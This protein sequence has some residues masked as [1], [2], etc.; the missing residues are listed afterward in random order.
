MKKEKTISFDPPATF[1]DGLT[2]D[3]AV[4]AAGK[5]AVSVE[6]WLLQH[7]LILLGSPAV[8]VKL[9]NG[10]KI[11][12]C[13]KEPTITALIRNRNALYKL[14]A[15]PNLYFGDLYSAG[16]IEV[17]GDLLQFLEI[18]YTAMLRTEHNAG[19]IKKRITEFLTRAP[20]ANTLAGS[21]T[22]IDHHYD[23][24]NE[25][26][27][28][29][30]DR[31]HMQYTCAYYPDEAMTLQQAQTAKLEHICRKLELKPG[32]TVVEAGCGWG[33]LA[34]YM[35]KHYDVKVKSYNI[36]HEQ[37][38]FA[39]QRAKDQGLDGKVEYI[40]D[41]YRNI[42]GEFDAFVS[43]GM[44]EHVGHNNYSKLGEVIH[45]CLKPEG[46]GFIHSIGRNEP[47]LMN[48]WIEKRIFPGAYPPAL[49]EMMDIFEPSN[50][51]VQDVENL[52]RHYARTL[53]HWLQRYDENIEQVEAMFDKAF[54]RAWRLYLVGSIAAFNTGELQ[55]FQI[56]FTRPQNNP[57][58]YSRA[59]LYQ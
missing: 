48:A 13:D 55:L 28:L 27:T 35:A 57:L 12:V 39:R 45:R 38:I 31:D 51:S 58:S 19:P 41:D 50:F 52:G 2:Y 15:N 32:E 16:Q 17:E 25:F 53:E 9:W 7:M 22:H 3:D 29:W 14:L 10:D 54:V 56:L 30:L 5:N 34:R 59:H 36:S 43:I 46:R 33:G 26:Y 6:I 49:R 18:S 37:V 23:I 21:R 1:L 40:E 42:T 24:G 8:A 11:W 20:R 47:A 4:E 44:L